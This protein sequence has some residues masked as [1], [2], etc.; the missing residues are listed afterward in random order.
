[1]FVCMYFCGEFTGNTKNYKLWELF[2]I[3]D[4]YVLYVH[5]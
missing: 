4:T 1:M 3:I 5:I 2:V